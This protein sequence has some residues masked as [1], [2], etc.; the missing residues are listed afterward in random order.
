MNSSKHITKFV[1]LLRLWHSDV[2]SLRPLCHRNSSD[3][4]QQR[5]CSICKEIHPSWQAARST[6]TLSMV[7][8]WETIQGQLN[9]C[10]SDLTETNLDSD[11]G[12]EFWRMAIYKLI[13]P[14]GMCTRPL[15]APTSQEFVERFFSL[16]SDDC[17][18]NKLHGNVSSQ[19]CISKTETVWVTITGNYDDQMNRL[20]RWL[21]LN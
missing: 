1:P 11:N 12:I 18:M 14:L 15:S 20:P 6:E 21:Q 19:A 3:D 16:C 10:I 2:V 5:H 17:R 8:N 4:W 13:G 7:T 9:R